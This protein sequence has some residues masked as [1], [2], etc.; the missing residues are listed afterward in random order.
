M[1]IIP[2]AHREFG[3]P[4]TVDV[5]WKV[6][7]KKNLHPNAARNFYRK[8]RRRTE[9]THGL[10]LHDKGASRLGV[11]MNTSSN[12]SGKLDPC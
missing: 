9:T 11:R 12:L 2:E 3:Q 1:S 8:T 5:P 4:S 6:L 10:K 7:Q